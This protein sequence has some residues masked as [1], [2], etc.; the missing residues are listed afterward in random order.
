MNE[1]DNKEKKNMFPFLLVVLPFDQM[2]PPS[3]MDSISSLDTGVRFGCKEAFP[4]TVP[5]ACE[6]EKKLRFA[7]PAVDVS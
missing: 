7:S 4:P 5:G 2:Q 3:K 1:E 6:F